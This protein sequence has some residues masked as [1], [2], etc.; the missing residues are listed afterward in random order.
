MG[1]AALCA[2]AMSGSQGEAATAGAI[3]ASTVTLV[4]AQVVALGLF[5]RTY[6]VVYLG[7]SEPRLE[8]L[9]TR[10]RLEHGLLVSALVLL[11]GAALAIYAY[12]DGA[13]QP[14]VAVLALTLIALGAQGV[15]ASFFLSILGLAEHALLRVP[16]RR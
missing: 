16:R 12:S 13:A 5:A 2:L 10:M 8:R 7:E 3:V 15:F 4:G 14:P 11:V 9:W 6:A 1:F